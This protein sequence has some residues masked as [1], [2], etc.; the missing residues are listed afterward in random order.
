MSNEDF[1]VAEVE[2]LM[3]VGMEAYLVRDTGGPRPSHTMDD[4]WRA[5][6]TAGGGDTSI[7]YHANNELNRVLAIARRKTKV[8]MG[9]PRHLHDPEGFKRE[10]RVAMD[11]W[12]EGKKKDE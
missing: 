1:P 8:N 2:K 11:A 10:A 7:V 6:C 9:T 5:M 12:S 4:G 3:R